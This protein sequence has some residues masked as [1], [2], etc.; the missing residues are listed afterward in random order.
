MHRIASLPALLLIGCVRL[1]QLALSPLLQALGTQC[2]FVPSC[3]EYFI[4]AVRKYGAISGTLRGLWRICRSLLSDRTLAED[5]VQETALRILEGLPR[6]DGRS[7]VS[8]WATGIAL[9]VCREL[10][11]GEHRAANPPQHAFAVMRYA[12]AESEELARLHEALV[13]LPERQR[14][15]V[16]LRFLEALDVSETAELMGC[17]PGTVKASVHAGL[18]NLRRMM[19]GEG[20]EASA[21]STRDGGVSEN[22]RRQSAAT[23]WTE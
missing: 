4:H 15:A 2:R 3:S 6:F 7:R 9:N 22:E 23:R 18:G 8:T 11:R 10:R 14:E 5:A 16:V 21:A 17:A 20:R 19:S 1:Y 12:E 13:N